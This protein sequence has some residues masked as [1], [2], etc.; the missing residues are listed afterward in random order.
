[1]PVVVDHDDRRPIACAQTFD[2]EQ[3][4]RAGRIRFSR[5]D[6]DGFAERL[7]DALGAHQRTGQR[8]TDV[9][10]VFADGS[11]EEHRVVRHDVLDLRRRASDLIGDIPHRGAVR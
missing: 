11:G 9:Q 8:P 1:M 2:L 5:A 6:A 10:D 3:R 4:E 7:G